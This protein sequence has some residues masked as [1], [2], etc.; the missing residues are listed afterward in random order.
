MTVQFVAAREEDFEPLLNLARAMNA[1]DGHPLDGRA[2]A[3][4]AGL[5]RPETAA[6]AWF[7][8]EMP[9]PRV[10]GYVALCAGY[11]IEHGGRDGFVDEL[12]V[13]PEARGR[14]LGAALMA[15]A[16]KAAREKGISTLHLEV[17][18]G[19]ARAQTLYRSRGYEDTGRVLMSKRL[20]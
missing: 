2:E 6:W 9:G 16:E 4:V 3:A 8:Q 19:N 20:D 17:E 13:I 1:E 14:G 11:S 15:F 18:R 10:V 12:Y 7:A 5:L